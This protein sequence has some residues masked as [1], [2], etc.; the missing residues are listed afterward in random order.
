MAIKLVIEVDDAGNFNVTG[1]INDKVM[2]YGLLEA[3]KDAIR[4]QGVQ[5]AIEAASR[6]VPAAV[7]P[8]PANGRFGGR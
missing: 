1:P 4:A 7:V 5:K 3:A 6:I 8:V 2:C